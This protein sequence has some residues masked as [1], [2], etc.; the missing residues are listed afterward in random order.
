MLPRLPVG[1]D[2]AARVLELRGPEPALA[3]A[4]GAR[5][6]LPALRALTTLRSLAVAPRGRAR[7][8]PGARRAGKAA[9]G[10]RLADRRGVRAA[11]RRGGRARA[12]SAAW[13]N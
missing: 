3:R 7:S 5:D 11:A 8:V 6:L 1:V 12:R 4:A 13:R 10:R 2:P 9:A